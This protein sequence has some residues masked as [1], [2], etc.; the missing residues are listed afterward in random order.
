M[1]KPEYRLINGDSCK[2]STIPK[3]SVDLAVTSPPYNVGIGYKGSK[4]DDEI[5]YD[6]YLQFSKKWI[7]NVF[8]WMRPTG[9]LCIN[10]GLDKSKHGKKPTCADLTRI[11]LDAGWKYH[12]TIIWNEGTISKRTAWGSWLSASAPHVIAPV[13]SIIVLYKNEWKR[14]RK[15][16]STIQRDEFMEWTNGLWTFGGAKKNGHP[17]PFPQELPER[18]IKL[19]SYLDDAVLDPFAGSGTTIIAAMKNG[20]RSI[21]IELSKEYCNLAERRIREEASQTQLLNEA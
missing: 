14:N 13:E 12:C 3:N 19:F 9:R 11:A 4:Y 1:K 8:Y 18:C 15:G 16:P 2:K 21:G 10:V 20:R 17:A 7:G 6:D 5:S